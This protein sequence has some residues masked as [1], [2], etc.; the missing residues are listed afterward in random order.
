MEYFDIFFLS[1]LVFY[2]SSISWA[3]LQDHFDFIEKK[4]D[5]AST[6]LIKKSALEIGNNSD[7]S[8]VFTAQLLAKCSNIKCEEIIQSYKKNAQGR[9]GAVVGE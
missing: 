3:S 9:S 1:F 6:L 2:S 5:Q 8:Q 7:C 4:C